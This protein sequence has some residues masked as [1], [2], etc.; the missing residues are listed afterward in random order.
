M[1][2]K[3]R[4][5]IEILGRAVEWRERA[6][7]LRLQQL[8]LIGCVW[9]LGFGWGLHGQALAQ[10]GTPKSVF[11]TV[12][13]RNKVPPSEP[14]AEALQ[15]ADK[16]DPVARSRGGDNRAKTEAAAKE[17]AKARLVAPATGS[18]TPRAGGET[19]PRAAM[20]T[21]AP[22]AVVKSVG[23]SGDGKRSRFQVAMSRGVRAEIF[24]LANPYR[25]IVDLPDVTFALAEGTG[26]KGAGLISAF[27]YGLFAERKGRIVL[28]ASAPVRISTA[29]MT[30]ARQGGVVLLVELDAI[31]A[32][33]FG[34]GTGA[35]AAS[36]PPKPAI[37]D[38]GLPA[39]PKSAKPMIVIDP[40][41]GGIDPGAIGV[42]NISEKSVVLAVAQK[43]R[44][45][46]E[47][48]GRY[49][50]E[51]TRTTDVFV[52]LD[53]RVKISHEAGAD[54]FVSL[55]ADSIAA[56]AYSGMVRGASVY[57][58][59]ERASDEKARMK[60]EKENASDALAGLDNSALDDANSEVRNIL[61]DLM[62]RETSNFSTDFSNILVA[63]LRGQVTL[64][65][66]PQ[67][68]A[69]F[70]V[71]KQTHAPSVLV[72][73]GYISNTADAALM[74]QPDWQGK[75]AQTIVG[76][77][78]AFFDKRTARSAP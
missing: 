75:L 2:P 62:K 50:V 17:S 36:A 40:G 35:S 9:V 28:D 39:K 20:A 46:L 38:D 27:R 24:T 59:S 77:V 55:H 51:L 13:S 21:T 25:V 16:P 61:M 26:R 33:E 12:I 19:G 15:E 43:M 6:C 48:T 4:S 54:L 44:R 68:A 23:V 30:P 49:R 56:E 63:R 11:D 47:A 66:E 69:A 52:A 22:A 8:L 10:A 5:V 71:L 70:K 45:R 67:R 58:L 41:H 14:A 65:R 74:R 31:S 7:V 37:F 18:D 64:T 1:P 72:E 60:A 32:A 53:Q 42:D 3:A 34:A 76:A 78:D 29:K 57:T 73:L